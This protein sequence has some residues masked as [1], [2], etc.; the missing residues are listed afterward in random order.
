M[1]DGEILKY[2]SPK[3]RFVL[4]QANRVVSMM[5]TVADG[6]IEGE[7]YNIVELNFFYR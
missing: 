6:E 3:A 7:T 2:F 1:S 5:V 4:D